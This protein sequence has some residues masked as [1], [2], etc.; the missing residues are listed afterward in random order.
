MEVLKN[1]FE[2]ILPL[3][4]KAVEEADYI[5]IDTEL[6]GL[7]KQK[8]DVLDD[9]QE[10][11]TKLKEAATEHLIVQFG[12]CTFKWDA[13]SKSYIAKPF[14]AYVYPRASSRKLEIDR[15]FTVQSACF[16]FLAENKFDFNKWVSQG[17]PYLTHE[18]E[19]EARR[20]IGG[21][22]RDEVAV[23]ET[24]REFVENT[25]KTVND[26]LQNSSEKVVSVACPT[27]FHRLLVH[28]EVKKRF[29]AALGTDGKYGAVEVSKLTE[30]ERKYRSV[31]KE[32]QLEMELNQLI[33][34]RKVIDAISQSGSIVLG[35]NMFLD[36]CH[37]FQ[38]FNRTLPAD[39]EEFRRE[40][41][42]LFPQ[43]I[44]TK[45]LARSNP[46]LSR[47]QDTGLG[48]VME[49]VQKYP[50]VSPKISIDP[51]CGTYETAFHEAGYD[52]Y[53]TGVAFLRMTAYAE[54]CGDTEISKESPTVTAVMNKLNLMK[55]DV[56]TLNLV[57][58]QETRDRSHVF[59]VYGFSDGVKTK[60]VMEEFQP[61]AGDISIQWI[62]LSSCFITL[63]DPGKAEEFNKSLDG[64]DKKFHY[65]IESWEAYKAKNGQGSGLSS[66]TSQQATPKRKL[67][68]ESPVGKSE[69]SHKRTKTDQSSDGEKAECAVM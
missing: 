65:E 67:G 1:N 53:A 15:H 58:P 12:V 37:T 24:H 14:N 16:E 13:E 44:D 6:S 20:R 40:V 9:S 46:K 18:E 5:A 11:Y 43:I 66:S 56:P 23:E 19:A 63:K 39:L 51:D 30:E 68:L 36:L 32:A 17:I 64:E 34:F 4:E 7:G 26:W 41:H 38:Q 42:D 52:A 33:G 48:A 22:R 69:S 31:G 3:I 50:F 59:R 28:Q 27:S 8:L 10:R 45:H 54:G 61:R 55:S 21:L 60:D 29:G 62:N 57:G 35:H 49:E 47:L 25:I 2:A